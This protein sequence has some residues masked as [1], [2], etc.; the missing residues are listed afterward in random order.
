M[1]EPVITMTV[2]QWEE[3]YEPFVNHLD[4]DASWATDDANGI[5]FETYGAEVDYV[6]ARPLN[7]TWTY[8]DGEEGTYILAGRHLVN[9][10]GYFVTAVPWK[11][12]FNTKYEIQVS[13]NDDYYQTV[14]D[15][16]GGNK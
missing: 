4:A 8:V 14:L 7:H 13:A 3:Q 15:L 11:D 16:E 10:I 9:R 2:E 5:M 6:Y 12:D 1:L